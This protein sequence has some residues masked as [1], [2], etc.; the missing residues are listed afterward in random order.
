MWAQEAR[1]ASEQNKKEV[2]NSLD[3]KAVSL[4]DDS[5]HKDT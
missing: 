5:V 3:V 4:R 2:F 1:K